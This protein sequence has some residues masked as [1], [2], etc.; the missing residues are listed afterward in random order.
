[1]E[2]PKD[3]AAAIKQCWPR[4]VVE[5]FD[6]E[7]SY[8]QEIRRQIERDLGG[9]SGALLVWQTEEADGAGWDDDEA[10]EPLPSYSEFQS[11]HVFF[12]SPSGDE[13]RFE[14]KTIGENP[15]DGTHTTYP[16]EGRFGLVLTMS[17]AA[18][19]AAIDVS[20]YSHYE[21]GAITIPDPMSS[22]FWNDETG[23]AISANEYHRDWLGQE[24]FQ[25]LEILRQQI[26]SI[27]AR[28]HISVLDDSVLDLPVKGLRADQEVFAGKPL[29]VRDAFFFRGV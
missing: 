17:L 4:G 7:E 3:L 11:Y 24:M 9:I 10:D 26:V 29:R 28:R 12:I 16:G 15:E 6:A 19:V 27:V 25:T 2:I 21:D 5:E 14:D 8:F 13:F 23:E 18:P 1:M 22:V 20:S